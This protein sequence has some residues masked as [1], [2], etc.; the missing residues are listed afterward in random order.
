MQY[1]VSHRTAP[2]RRP[3]VIEEFT[4]PSGIGSHRGPFAPSTGESVRRHAS[5]G[6]WRLAR[7]ECFA[8]IGTRHAGLRLH[9]EM[10]S[11]KSMSLPIQRS[12]RY[13]MDRRGRA[14]VSAVLVPTTSHRTGPWPMVGIGQGTWPWFTEGAHQAEYAKRA[15]ECR[16]AR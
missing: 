11:E 12:Y 7:G 5:S 2:P 1:C 9:E 16:I 13:P 3:I 4:P 10:L 8:T 14:V 15:F 6:T